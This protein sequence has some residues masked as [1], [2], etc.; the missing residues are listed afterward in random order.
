MIKTYRFLLFSILITVSLSGALGQ[1]R[2]VTVRLSD[3]SGKVTPV[4]LYEKSYALII[5]ESMYRYPSSWKPLDG[6]RTDVPIVEKLL[7]ESGFDEV[8]VKQ[9][10]TRIELDAAIRSF[11]AKYGLVRENRLLIYYAGHG[12]TETTADGVKL[13]YIIP[14]DTPSPRQ[15]EQFYQTALSMN[16]IESYAISI[17]AKHA[18]FIFDSCFSGSILR[19]TRGI[20]PT[21]I[22][23]KA[24]QP[25]RYYITS[26]SE[27][28]EVPDISI[29][30]R[31]FEAG[32]RGE[33]DLN[34]DGYVTGTELGSFLE[35][36]VT[37]Y[38]KGAQT[39]L[40]GRIANG[41]LDKGDFIFEVIGGVRKPDDPKNP[42]DPNSGERAAWEQIARSTNKADFELFIRTFPNGIFISEARSRYEQV[43]WDS[44]KDSRNRAD[45]QTFL[46]TFPNSQFVPA[47]KFAL[48]RLKTPPPPAGTVG[49]ARLLNL[50]DMSF[51]YIP[52]GQFLMGGEVQLG[53]PVHAVT[54]SEG[55]WIGQTEV[56][57]QQWQAIM[58]NNPSKN[59]GCPRCP[60]ESVSWDDAQEFIK[61]LN[62]A[63]DGYT[64]RLPTEAEWEY[65]CRA[66][67]TAPYAGDLNA[68]AW[69]GESNYD[70]KPKEVATKTPN[71]WGLYDMHGNVNEWVQDWFGDYSAGSF[72]DPTGPASG[73]NRTI[74]S[75]SFDVTAPYAQS[76]FR[77]G[78]PQGLRNYATGFRIVRTN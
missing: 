9:D 50:V 73:S 70:N 62:A 29:F 2:G 22:T 59:Q 1:S 72:R 5:G 61:K 6:V 25:I 60:V 53:K 57:Q 10:L 42:N 58:G 32:L 15:A 55:F 13:G 35:E 4:K 14:I 64:Y 21:N 68:M 11:I 20:P 52:T 30:R 27:D 16:D 75:G 76:A 77:N 43:W 41:N 34:R 18:L 23:M 74:R 33:A 17:R 48:E 12:Y 49:K 8:V 24:T 39:P 54:I 67:S 47:A 36:K 38:S 46:G 26:G 19:K 69:Y 28:Q 78:Y 45:F 63:N 44:I 65:A 3:D 31:E 56:T 51:A 7:R 37:N 66:G 40:S 71:A